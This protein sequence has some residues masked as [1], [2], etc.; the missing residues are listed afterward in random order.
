MHFLVSFFFFLPSLRTTPH[1]A[2]QSKQLF[3][4][5]GHLLPV[6]PFLLNEPRR[7]AFALDPPRK[8]LVSKPAGL[9]TFVRL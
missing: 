4:F 5:D 1:K 2:A 6:Q 7:S 8:D 3:P 9:L